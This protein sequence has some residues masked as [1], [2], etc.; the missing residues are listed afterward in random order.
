MGTSEKRGHVRDTTLHSPIGILDCINV[1]HVVK[2]L[3][4]H[5]V[6]ALSSNSLIR[7]IIRVY[8]Y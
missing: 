1:N 2:V 6:T 8:F 5:G 4:K 3:V 7:V